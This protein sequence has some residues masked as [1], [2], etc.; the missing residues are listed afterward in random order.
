MRPIPVT[1]TQLPTNPTAR[2][3]DEHGHSRYDVFFRYHLITLY[4]LINV[5]AAFVILIYE[6]YIVCCFGLSHT[7]EVA[8]RCNIYYIFLVRRM[9]AKH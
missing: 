6:Q 4:H 5:P 9:A 2:P 1:R 8:L 3:Y 7:T